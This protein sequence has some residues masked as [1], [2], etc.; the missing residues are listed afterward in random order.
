MSGFDL[1]LFARGGPVMWVLLGLALLGLM[2]FI[3]RSLY[4]HR[5]QIRAK[6]FVD[7][8]KNTL[9]KRRL[10]EALTLCEE[11]PGP[12]AAVVKA[13]LLHANDSADQMRFHVQEAGIVELPALERR[14]GSI[15]AIAQVAPLVGLL[16]T[17]L[18]MIGTF[19]AF[20]KGGNY[21]MAGALSAGM[22]Q[23]LLT[24][25]ASLMLA[26]PAH[27]AYHFLSGRVRAIVRDVEWSGNEIMKYL[28]TEYRGLTPGGE[29]GGA[30]IPPGPA[31]M[32]TANS[33]LSRTVVT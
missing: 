19:A 26:I 29:T 15:A 10:V 30:G 16:G 31:S 21:A 28:L 25:A 18:G 4:L 11:T 2:L 8:I 9:A 23:A 33:P 14:L 5:G 1:S 12:V 32:P 6:A 22:W 27:L 13:A 3:E 7:G 17:V 20:E 24:A